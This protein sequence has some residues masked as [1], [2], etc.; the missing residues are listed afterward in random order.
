MKI[1][2]RIG[3]VMIAAVLAFASCQ[4]VEHKELQAPKAVLTSLEGTWKLVKAT[5]VDEDAKTK[6]FPFRELDL[7]PLFAY[8]DFK[9]TLNM[10]AGAPTTFTTTP[11]NSP[12]IIR[13]TSGNWSVDNV[14]FPKDI[15]LTS[16]AITEKVT[17]GGYPVGPNNTLKLKVER[18]VLVPATPTTPATTKLLITYTYEFAKQ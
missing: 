3:F 12:K 18:K 2:V 10:A 15:T 9:L 6:G 11:G 5:Q 4:P 8:S 7:T 16:G 1:N 17:L 13:L 14:D